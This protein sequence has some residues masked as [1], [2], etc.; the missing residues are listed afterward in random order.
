MSPHF[1]EVW[2]NRKM[3][4]QPKIIGMIGQIYLKSPAGSVLL[5]GRGVGAWK[6]QF[7]G[8][9]TNQHSFPHERKT[10]FF[11]E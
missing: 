11:M 10:Y 5:E 3:C 6:K 2:R 7:V 1:A 4:S 8:V 9:T